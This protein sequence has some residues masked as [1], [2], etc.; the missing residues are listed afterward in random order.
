MPSLAIYERL[1]HFAILACFAPICT[2]ALL[3]RV[4]DDIPSISAV[5]GLTGVWA[6]AFGLAAAGT[7]MGA[8]ALLC[9]HVKKTSSEKAQIEPDFTPRPTPYHPDDTFR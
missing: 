6:L 2:L 1:A 8:G 9:R 4:I 7:L 3:S 5:Q